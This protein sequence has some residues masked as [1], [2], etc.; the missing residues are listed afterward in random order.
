M[1]FR[2]TISLKTKTR[3]FYPKCLESDA[4]MMQ[5]RSSML[6]AVF[7]DHYNRLPNTDVSRVLWEAASSLFKAFFRHDVTCQIDMHSANQIDHG[8]PWKVAL[9]PSVPAV[10]TPRKPK[11]W[12][13]AM[14]KLRA[15][16]AH[17]I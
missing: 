8:C 11:F 7:K 1:S 10:I 4:D 5:L 15:K 2:Y 6:G 16:H 9:E 3:C 13:C 14:V 17:R 12:L